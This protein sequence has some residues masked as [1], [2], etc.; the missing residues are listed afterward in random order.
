M[1]S[2]AVAAA[3]DT[4]AFSVRSLFRSLLRQ[5]NQFANYN[6]REYAKRRTRD[7]FREHQHEAD[8]RKVQEFVQKG[9]QELQMMKVSLLH[10]LVWFWRTLF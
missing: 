10:G 2:T 8:P 4:S 1:A 5:S 7:G 9:I 6:F 3:T